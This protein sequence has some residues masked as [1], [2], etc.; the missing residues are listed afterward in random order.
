MSSEDAKSVDYGMG[1]GAI[2]RKGSSQEISK[3]GLKSKSSDNVS[4]K[5]TPNRP[6]NSGSLDS[7]T[8]KRMLANSL[9]NSPEDKL[10]PKPPPK[11]D[12]RKPNPPP[13]SSSG[14]HRGGGK[15]SKGGAKP[16][17]SSKDTATKSKGA[18]SSS[19]Q[20]KSGG[21]GGGSSG[22]TLPKKKSDAAGGG[23]KKRVLELP[24]RERSPPSDNLLYDN[25][26]YA[27]TP[28]TSNDNS[29]G[30]LVSSEDED[31]QVIDPKP[32]KEP[33]RGASFKRPP[34]GINTP[35]ANS[36]TN[37]LLMEYEM[38]LRNALARGLDAESYSLSTFE[39]L[40]TQ[41]MENVGK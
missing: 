18:G 1:M 7:T 28:S 5:S 21:G 3:D 20:G 14:H 6:G 2:L 25:M 15:S 32:S 12:T 16:S 41:S 27:T 39:A 24:D 40:L 31:E 4:G 19:K 26:C 9:Q 22:G 11:P 17:S 38:H 36:P 13:K 37:K 23:G 30:P 10:K 8:A 34:C 33:K 29:D 35:S